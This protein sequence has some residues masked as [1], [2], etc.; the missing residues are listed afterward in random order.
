MNLK[1]EFYNF[2]LINFFVKI[3]DFNL[4]RKALKILYKINDNKIE[5]LN[6]AWRLKYVG[7][8]QLTNLSYCYEIYNKKIEKDIFD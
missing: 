6:F 2:G 1:N 7:G 5:V 3:L 4:S 8:K